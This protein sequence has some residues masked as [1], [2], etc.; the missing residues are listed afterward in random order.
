MTKPKYG[1]CQTENKCIEYLGYDI[2]AGR[3][4]F[5]YK[6]LTK[7][8]TYIRCPNCKKRIQCFVRECSDENCMHLWMPKHKKRIK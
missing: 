5:G 2:P 7:S 4:F 8:Q 3:V 1:W 6:K